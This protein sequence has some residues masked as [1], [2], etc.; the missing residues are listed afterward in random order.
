MGNY[1]SVLKVGDRVDIAYTMNVFNLWGNDTLSLHLADIRPQMPDSIEWQKP[2]TLE[3]LY[4]SGLAPEQ[5]AKLSKGA[6]KS[7]LIP[8]SEQYGD[9]YKTIKAVFFWPES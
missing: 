2:D 9:T 5:I 7:I 3:K 1:S 4:A 6:D 8:D